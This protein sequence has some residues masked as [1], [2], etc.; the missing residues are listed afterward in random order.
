MEVHVMAEKPFESGKRNQVGRREATVPAIGEPLDGRHFLDV[1][2]EQQYT[3]KP[4][5]Q[6]EEEEGTAGLVMNEE[7]EADK[8]A[9]VKK[10]K[11]S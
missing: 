2:E 1:V 4:F 3:G 5:F 7:A 10:E 8:T 9:P 6:L 11:K